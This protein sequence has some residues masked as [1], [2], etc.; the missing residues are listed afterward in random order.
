V[1][2]RGV[3]GEE[4]P[5]APVR[6]D[7]A[8]GVGESTDPHRFGGGDVGVG[9][10]LEDVSDL[11]ELGGPG[12]SDGRCAAFGGDDAGDA[13]GQVSHHHQT[14][15]GRV[16]GH[17]RREVHSADICEVQL[18]RRGRAGEVEAGDPADRAAAAVAADDK[19]RPQG[20]F[21][22]GDAHARPVGVLGEP[23]DLLAAP[24]VGTQLPC[25]G[26]QYGLGAGLG[27]GAGGTVRGAEDGEVE[28]QPAEVSGGTGLDVAEAGQQSSLVEELHRADGEPDAAG[29][30]GALGQAVEDQDVDAG[31]AQ[32]PGQH[33]PGGSGADND[34]GGVHACLPSEVGRVGLVHR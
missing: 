9:Q 8:G 21:G 13:V 10:A 33:E 2:V 20:L 1:D 27:D 24:D 29:L 31:Q 22:A 34:D 14:A 6:G 28:R 18:G 15:G 7:L 23:R 25:P 30:T 17:L 32:F 3:A 11:A 5:A 26:L 4:D 19:A 12:A 16:G